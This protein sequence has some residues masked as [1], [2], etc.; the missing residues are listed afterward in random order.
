MQEIVKKARLLG[1]SIELLMGYLQRDRQVSFAR[2]S[3]YIGHSRL[4]SLVAV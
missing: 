2:N 4:D 1:I 3:F